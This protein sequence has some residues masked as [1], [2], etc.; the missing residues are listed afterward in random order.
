MP[1]FTINTT[2]GGTPQAMGAAY[3]SLLILTAQTTPLSRFRVYEIKMG[4]SAA[5]NATDTYVEYDL[6]L[7]T[8][9]G[10]ATAITPRSAD[11]AD[12]GTQSTV[13]AANATVEG[14]ITA[15]S[16][17]LYIPLNQRAS[18]RWVAMAADDMLIAPAV[19]LA[20]FAFRARSPVYAGTVGATIRFQE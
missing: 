12:Q 19:N 2:H 13:C 4:T 18:F 10:T 15:A 20:G 9:A 1:K 3:K 6:S 14:T 11:P 16:S 8:A 5:P 7:Q 17:V